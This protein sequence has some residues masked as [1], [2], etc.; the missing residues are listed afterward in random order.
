MEFTEQAFND[1][2]ADIK[3][4]LAPIEEKYK[5]NIKPTDVTYYRLSF[6]MTLKVDKTEHD[7]KPVDIRKE[8]FLDYCHD[9]DLKPE[10]Y[11]AKCHVRGDVDTVYLIAGIDPNA[12]TKNIFIKRESDGHEFVIARNGL[13]LDTGEPMSREKIAEISAQMRKEEERENF[14][15]YCGRYGFKPED[16]M[17]KCHTVT[18]PTTTYLLVNIKPK[19]RKYPIILENVADKTRVKC[20]LSAVILDKSA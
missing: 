6:T 1:L 7:G 17:A 4:A 15:L 9:Y 3:K 11:M 18:H 20:P 8:N 12:R 19:N 13:I 5:L 10:H 16:Y 2:R 14:M